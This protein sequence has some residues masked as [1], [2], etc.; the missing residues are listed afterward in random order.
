MTDH[1]IT[2]DYKSRLQDGGMLLGD[3][4]YRTS[5]ERHSN[6]ECEWEREIFHLFP[7]QPQQPGL[8]Q[9]ESKS[10]ELRQGLPQEEQRSKHLGSYLLP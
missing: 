2:E 9:A 4:D 8:G 10:P 1:K 5:H 6:W 3:A 7:K